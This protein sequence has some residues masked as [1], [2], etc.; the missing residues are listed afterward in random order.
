MTL[1][2]FL[3]TIFD[4]QDYTCFTDSPFGVSV[5][6]WPKADDQ[7]FCINALEPFQDLGP[8]KAWHREDVPRRA[9]C[10]V[11]KFRTFLIELDKMD[12]AKQI[13][14]VKSKLPVTAITF[15]GDKSYHFLI[16]LETPLKSKAEYVHFF[17]R[18]QALLPEIDPANKNPSRLSRLP[19]AKRRE[20]GNIQKLVEL[21]SRIP[22]ETLD[23]L[24]P[25]ISE[26]V[27]VRDFTNP[28][29]REYVAV[30]IFEACTDPEQKINEK[31]LAG[32]NVFFYWLSCRMADLGYPLEQKKK[33]VNLAYDN[34]KNKKDFSINEALTAA[35]LM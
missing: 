5:G 8:T 18:I 10:N 9:D 11:T 34:L 23:K 14:Y 2:N 32:R 4:N 7:F 31:N 21:N 15:S 27:F 28:E 1:S 25:N 6:I 22:F 3:K 26:I 19:S 20:T 24:L 35:R 30:E 16:S 17:K 33:Y 13:D 12:L 29:T